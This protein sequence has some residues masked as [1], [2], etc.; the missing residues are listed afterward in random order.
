MTV[1]FSI[2]FTLLFAFVASEIA[3]KLKFQR[4]LGQLVF[5][6]ILAVPLLQSAL[7]SADAILIVEVFAELGIIF[8]LLQAG[9]ELNLKYL[10]KGRQD[11][12]AV[13][14][15]SVI[16]SFLCGLLV[17]YLFNMG[18]ITGVILGACLA[19]TAEGTTHIALHEMRKEKTYLASVILGAG[20][21]DDLVEIVFLLIVLGI[22]HSGSNSEMILF[23]AKFLLFLIILLWA[24]RYIPGLMQRIQQSHSDLSVFHA[25]LA[26]GLI[27]AMISDWVGLGTI[28]GAFIAGILLQKS[29]R[30]EKVRERE[31]HTLHLLLFSFI[32]PF[33]FI[34]IGINFEYHV[35][36]EN[37]ILTLSVLIAAFVGKIVGTLIA[38]PFTTLRWQQLYLVGWGMN[39]RGIMELVLAHVAFENGLI[40]QELYSA[41]VFMAVVTTI[42]FP[43]VFRRLIRQN[44]HI[45]DDPTSVVEKLTPRRKR[46][47]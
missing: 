24:F 21:I 28:S 26:L 46:K 44:P 11:A 35:L 23:P 1:L 43:L 38:K 3:K 40:S 12:I 6:L 10:K 13:A 25:F 29:F 7:F 32:V 14:T 5:S 34:H 19:V 2:T 17:A 31:D 16:F 41:I 15:T 8:L 22:T 39:S 30:D 20:I 33:F 42:F 4:A 37:P 47:K 27:L 9:F 36:F 45:T 18:I